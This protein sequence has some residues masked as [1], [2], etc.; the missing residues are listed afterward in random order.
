MSP[1]PRSPAA[2]ARLTRRAFWRRF[3]RLEHERLEFKRSAHHLLESV[4]AMAM[5]EGGAILV[6]VA[7]DRRLVGCAPVQDTLDRIGFVAFETEVELGVRLLAVGG[8]PVALVQ[9][10][11]IRDRVVTTPDGRVL[12]RIGSA[13]QPVRGDAVARFVR[14]RDAAAA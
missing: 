9:V 4:V 14:A 6:G 13:N 7:D 5:G 2:P 3:G 1:L 11:A 8:V 10:P 12:R